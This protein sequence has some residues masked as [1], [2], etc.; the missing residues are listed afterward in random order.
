M[1]N[2][3]KKILRTM[4]YRQAMAVINEVFPIRQATQSKDAKA[5][6][7]RYLDRPRLAKH[8]RRSALELGISTTTLN[9]VAHDLKVKRRHSGFGKQKRT[10]WSLR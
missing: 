10:W 7:R 4:T 9:R 2:D 3:L 5:F 6:L 1:T 8:V